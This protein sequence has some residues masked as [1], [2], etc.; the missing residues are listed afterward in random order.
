[1]A[2]TWKC[3]RQT[4]SRYTM[5][6]LL[7]GRLGSFKMQPHHCY[8]RN[9]FRH[10]LHIPLQAAL[11]TIVTYSFIQGCLFA[12]SLS[13]P[14]VSAV[15]VHIT[16]WFQWV[17]SEVKVLFFFFPKCYF[18]RKALISMVVK[19]H[20]RTFP[21]RLKWGWITVYCLL[22]S[23]VRWLVSPVNCTLQANWSLEFN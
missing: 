1:M 4:V 6:C 15:H 11:C 16:S 23:D 5:C 18:E 2:A 12:E 13:L 20:R 9:T 14:L 22:T 21:P 19:G 17:Y 10:V 7:V 3:R 8:Y